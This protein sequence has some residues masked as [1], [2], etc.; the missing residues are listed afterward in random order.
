MMVLES[1]P[2]VLRER[3]GGKKTLGHNEE[4]GRRV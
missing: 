3:E 2:A 4:G 1:H